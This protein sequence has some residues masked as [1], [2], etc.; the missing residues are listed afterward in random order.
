MGLSTP[1]QA[2]GRG[3]S[4]HRDHG[5]RIPKGYLQENGFPTPQVG[6]N[7]NQLNAWALK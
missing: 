1:F 6:P 3:R 4:V 5:R 2:Q 7:P